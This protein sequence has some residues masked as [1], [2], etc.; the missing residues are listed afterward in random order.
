M[1]NVRIGFGSLDFWQFVALSGHTRTRFL[2]KFVCWHF[3]ASLIFIILPAFG[4]AACSHSATPSQVVDTPRVARYYRIPWG[5]RGQT[6]RFSLFRWLWRSCDF[7][8]FSAPHIFAFTSAS[9]RA[10]FSAVRMFKPFGGGS[11]SYECVS[12]HYPRQTSSW[13]LFYSTR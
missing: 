12:P 13:R 9:K 2:G 3:G 7:W 8:K 1:Q 6:G 10:E 5:V 4:R 11:T